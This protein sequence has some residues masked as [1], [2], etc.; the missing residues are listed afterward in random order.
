VADDKTTQPKQGRQ[1]MPMSSLSILLHLWWVFTKLLTIDH[2][3]GGGVLSREIKHS[4]RVILLW[5]LHPWHCFDFKIFV[6]H[7]VNA[8]PIEVVSLWHTLVKFKHRR[9]I[10]KTA[11]Q[12]TS[13]KCV[14][15]Q[16]KNKGTTTLVKSIGFPKTKQSLQSEQLF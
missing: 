12:A 5:L 16:Y 6:R 13:N 11:R 7:F 15:G 1:A 2:I 4:F 10:N 14:S 9:E 3:S 8:H